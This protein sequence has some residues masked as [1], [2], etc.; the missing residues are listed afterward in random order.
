[1]IYPHTFEDKT[2]FSQI[3]TLL[4]ERCVSQMARERVDDLL[5]SS[6][7]EEV[8]LYIEQTDEFRSV[9]LFEDPF[10]AQDF[11]DLR[12][13][14]A[15]IHIDGTFIEL[16]ELSELRGFINAI[17]QIFV[18][19][20]IRNDEEKFPR[21]WNL[22]K[23]I[24]L[25]KTLLESIN[26]VL[27]AKGNLRDNASD[28]LRRIKREIIRVSGEADKKIRRL[29]QTAKQNGLVK[30]DAEMTIRNGRLCIPVPSVF[31]RRMQG[32]IH[33]ESATGQ[34]VF[35]EPTEVFDANNALKDLIN[36]ERR[37]IIRILTEL[38]N[39]IRPAIPNLL[40]GHDFIGE[41]DFI[42]AKA[43]LAIE[44]NAIKPNLMNETMINWQDAIHP[45]LFVN[46]KGTGKKVVPLSLQ[47]IKEERILIISGPNAGGKSVCLK[48]V[49]LLQYMLQCGLLV[50]MKETSEMGVFED[51]FIDIGDEQSIDNDLST[52]SS[53]LYNLKFMVEHLNEKSLFLIDEFGSG[54]EPAL[55]GAMAE[56]ILEKIY[57]L[58]PFGIITTHFGNLK[59]FP[60]T[61]KEAIN[62]AMLFDTQALKPLFMLKVGKPGSSFTYEI[63][64]QIGLSQE[65]IDNAIA[66]S[67][68]AQIDYERKLEEIE[69]EKIEI[70]KTL[71]L[72]HSADD[73]LAL[74]IQEYTDKYNLLEKQRKDIL[75]QAKNQATSIIDGANKLIENTIR[76]IK[77]AQAET[78]KT[79]EI[80][81]E[82]AEK[83]EAI[84][85]Q[86]LPKSTMELPKPISVKKRISPK[87][88]QE[89]IEDAKIK[90]GDSVFMTDTQT[91]GEVLSLNGRDIT[92]G[93]SS[94]SLRTTID[95]V[96]KISKKEARM[97]SRGSKMNGSTISEVMNRKVAQFNPT[98][99]LRGYRADEAV[100][101]LEEY[102][103]EASLL[104]IKQVKIL[105]GKGN[106]ILR[107]VV[108]QALGKRKEVRT[109][110]DEVLELGGS[111]I[112]VA[113]L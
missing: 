111:G 57:D 66:K 40:I 11:Y 107:H 44:L 108:R 92:I 10:P 80:R 75:A 25:E 96:V 97:A 1:M 48:T 102:I 91:M 26:R 21:L 23:D 78:E 49:G 82:V 12:P 77:E 7:F 61:H 105:H 70:D 45:L 3:R 39:E 35:I 112:T 89:T 88:K 41:V 58:K 27:D 13:V 93:F 36:A 34:T 101:E 8:K 55:G 94:I 37:E 76:E 98:L 71:K 31:K 100:A 79:R 106:G 65:I 99:D 16:E 6:D 90:V 4:K 67:G 104:G 68:T 50:P 59:V 38:S 56:A 69:L 86:S 95:K 20:R 9:L 29:L 109:F 60:D 42:R 113:E 15:R 87:Q 30:E 54:T 33:D 28:E 14:F 2:G 43:K 5:Y 46:F 85:Q 63:A 81:K 74:M 17:V 103:D 83:K 73:Q 62:G 72:V 64:R 53:H 51:F 24:Q 84:K 22:C 32:F 47:L 19:F 52:Y 110:R 18:Y